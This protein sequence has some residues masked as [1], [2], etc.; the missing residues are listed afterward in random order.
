[1]QI[2]NIENL[3]T[4]VNT[5]SSESISEAVHWWP[6]GVSRSLNNRFCLAHVMFQ[7]PRGYQFA[8]SDLYFEDRVLT[9]VLRFSNL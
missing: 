4:F 2:T 5:G 3:H 1:M 9:E 7:H 6:L 8:V